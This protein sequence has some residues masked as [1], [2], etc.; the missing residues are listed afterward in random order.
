M[1]RSEQIAYCMAKLGFSDT[2]LAGHIGVTQRVLHD[3]ASEKASFRLARMVE[4]FEMAEKAGLPNGCL[5]SLLSEPL[6]LSQL[7]ESDE[8]CHSSAHVYIYN[9]YPEVERRMAF[10]WA[11]EIMLREIKICELQDLLRSYKEEN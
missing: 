9:D 3:E 1:K 4:L 7:D 6:D 5:S 10:T 11:I 8:D 2:M